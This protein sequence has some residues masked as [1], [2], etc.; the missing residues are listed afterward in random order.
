MRAFVLWMAA[1]AATPA[2]AVAKAAPA[3]A[4]PKKAAAPKKP[5]EPA[6]VEE[7]GGRHWRLDTPNGPVHVWV[8]PGYDRARAGVVVYVHGYN[9][10]LDEAWPRQK[11]AHQFRESAQDALFIA[12]QSPRNK[13][14][15]VRWGSL[16]ALLGAVRKAGIRVP[17]GTA[18]LVGHSGGYRCVARWL[19]DRRVSEV[20]LLDALYAEDDAFRSFLKRGRRLIL[21]SLD[22]LEQS[23][24]FIQGQAG[25]ARRDKIPDA[26][27]EFTKKER[28]ARV[29]LLES[30]Y[31]HAAIVDNGKTMPML[32]RLTPLNHL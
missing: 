30:Q 1:L 21:V 10:E 2:V 24:R 7:D 5:Q 25:V 15:P 28:R 14:E 12:P 16:A 18:V 11:L 32:L 22:T 29:L 13:G 20:I 6:S 23:R 3:K 4:A 26:V 8:P 31:A 17:G 19:A 9:T 27:G